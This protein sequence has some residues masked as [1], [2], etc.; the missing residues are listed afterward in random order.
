MAARVAGTEKRVTLSLTGDEAK[1]LVKAVEGDPS[2]HGKVK[3]AVESVAWQSDRVTGW[4]PPDQR[5]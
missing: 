2:L 1:A 4:V 3:E 5:K